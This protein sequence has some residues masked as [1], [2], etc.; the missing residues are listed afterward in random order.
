MNKKS[1]GTWIG[2]CRSM[3][4]APPF[5]TFRYT[6]RGSD[7]KAS[8]S[9]EYPEMVSHA[10]F[11]RVVSEMEGGLKCDDFEYLYTALLASLFS[12]NGCFENCPG[13][14]EQILEKHRH[15]DVQPASRFVTYFFLS[16]MAT[17][18]PKL[19]PVCDKF[20]AENMTKEQ[21]F[22]EW[23]AFAKH[24]WQ[25]FAAYID[26]EHEDNPFMKL[27]TVLAENVTE[28]LLEGSDFTTL[29]PRVQC[30]ILRKM[31]ERFP[32]TDTAIQINDYIKKE[33]FQ[34][35]MANAREFM[36]ILDL[37][38]I[39][40][41]EF[42]QLDIDDKT[43]VQF[44]AQKL[45][46]KM[47]ALKKSVCRMSLRAVEEGGK[48]GTIGTVNIPAPTSVTDVGEFRQVNSEEANLH[49]MMTSNDMM[50]LIHGNNHKNSADILKNRLILSDDD[51]VC[52]W[53]TNSPG[54]FL[55]FDFGSDARVNLTKYCIV[56][57][58]QG[59][60]GAHLDGWVVDGSNDH[61]IWTD[62]DTHGKGDSPSLNDK[63]S[64]ERY[65]P[66]EAAG[67]SYRYIRLR[68]TSPNYANNWYL[69]ISKIELY[70]RLLIKQDK[71]Q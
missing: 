52:Y 13:L 17:V 23:I 69:C 44:P 63:P 48:M 27:I 1:I 65:V 12:S 10:I 26:S 38:T 62:I 14:E 21:R 60:N 35:N 50:I 49:R 61:I 25:A 64:V 32:E 57:N 41:D 45:V 68:M 66:M 37:E 22:S 24:N 58:Q 2:N 34:K 19:K 7:E 67:I 71:T 20:A 39:T 18:Q 42:V 3:L 47:I 28:V 8:V 5:M 40:E 51:K 9:F 54:S 15:N 59:K 31:R 4:P 16:D 70:G 33:S 55:L 30:E 36:K 11:G 6:Y 53:S 56:T 29:L 46:A 43:L